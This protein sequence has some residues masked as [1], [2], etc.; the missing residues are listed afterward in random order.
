MKI[1]IAC[2]SYRRPNNVKTLKYLSS[3][4]VFVDEGEYENYV[5]GN[6]GFEKNIVSVP[7]GVQGNLCRIRNYMLD[8]AFEKNGYDAIVIVDDDLSY[9]GRYEPEKDSPYHFGYEKHIVK[10]DE[11]KI[12]IE[13]YFILC[14]EWGFKQWGLQCNSDAMAYRHYT[15]FS[16]VSYLGGPFQAFLKNPLRYDEELPLKEDYDMTL[17]QCNKYRGVLRCNFMFYE[18]DQSKSP[19]G[20]ANYR[21]MEREKQQ[22]ELLQRKWGRNIIYYDSGAKK[23]FDY[24]PILKVPIK[25]I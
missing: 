1:L 20:C 19:G 6:P 22:F 11:L 21:N 12:L 16:T 5:N 14:D 7:S 2:P 3:C 9:I 23:A 25:G 24:N 15:P 17:Q 10:E 4:L 8:W 18:C 13:K